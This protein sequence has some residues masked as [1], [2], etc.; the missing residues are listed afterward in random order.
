VDCEPKN[1]AD[2]DLR[3]DKESK[4]D[5]D[6]KI[7][8]PARVHEGISY[9]TKLSLRLVIGDLS[10]RLE[11]GM[12]SSSLRL[13]TKIGSLSSLSELLNIVY[14]G[15]SLTEGRVGFILR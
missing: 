6:I 4:G 8:Y 12:T 7:E 11:E 5:S 10:N 3:P 15:D 1:A 9:T 13:N 2:V 14:S